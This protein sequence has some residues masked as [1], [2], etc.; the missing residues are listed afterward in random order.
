MKN[1]LLNLY[2]RTRSAV[3]YAKGLSDVFSLSAEDLAKKQAEKHAS[4]NSSVK[5]AAVMP[6]VQPCQGQ[7]MPHTAVGDFIKIRE[8][9]RD[10]YDAGVQR[11]FSIKSYLDMM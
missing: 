7:R 8:A 10:S 2:S 11:A 4:I 5:Y 3:S 9:E 1:P 6:L